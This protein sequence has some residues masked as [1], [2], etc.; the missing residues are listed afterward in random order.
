M[1]LL[2]PQNA[3]S[4]T[5]NLPHLNCIYSSHPTHTQNDIHNLAGHYQQTF[6]LADKDHTVA[7][8]SPCGYKWAVPALAVRLKD[9]ESRDANF[10]F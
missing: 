7:G 6:L 3:S 8:S 5:K 1:L 9:S 4:P 2:F 10:H